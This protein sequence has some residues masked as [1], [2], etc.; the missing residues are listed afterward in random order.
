MDGPPR[1]I[2]EAAAVKGFTNVNK[3][4]LDLLLRSLHMNIPG[5]HEQKAG[6]IMEAFRAEWKW[7]DVD[8]AKAMQHNMF[9]DTLQSSNVPAQSREVPPEVLELAGAMQASEEIAQA[10]EAMASTSLDAVHET[11]DLPGVGPV[12]ASLLQALLSPGPA[13]SGNLQNDN[14]CICFSVENFFPH[15]FHKHSSSWSFSFRQEI[16][17]R[18]H[19]VQIRTSL[20]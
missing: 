4:V 17:W 20:F 12:R 9:G 13:P 14:I 19:H 7:S 18:L 5:A 11:V 8:M 10:N 6:A 2:L 15:P 1:S 16:F 3:T